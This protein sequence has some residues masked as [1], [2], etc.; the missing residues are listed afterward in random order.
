MVL[1]AAL[2]GPVPDASAQWQLISETPR[3]D[4]GHKAWQATRKVRSSVELSL[5]LIFFEAASTRQMVVIQNTPDRNRAK[6]V[7][8]LAMAHGAIAA[9]N[10]GYFS[11]EFGP[12]G[13]EIA[14]G[15]RRGTWQT[16]GNAGVFGV[17][18]GGAFL[19]PDSEFADSDDISALV[20]CSP[21]LMHDGKP[22]AH[23]GGLDR[24]A[25]SF[26]ATDDTGHW[27]MGFVPRATLDELAQALAS[28]VVMP[29]FNVKTALNL[30]GG[31]S[32]SQWWKPA[33]GT[34][35][36]F[37]P[38]AIVRNVILICPKP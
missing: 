5:S 36:S 25:R 17:R 16:R 11:P 30:D 27:V 29:G 31:P 32:S 35:Q 14:Q 13:L 1:A 12:D 34:V 15:V 7:P 19:L 9:C 33:N 23:S 37:R 4:L 21:L 22:M 26:I 28:P 18:N 10:G 6:T 3:Q 2:L 8:E 24:V 38:A 20:Q